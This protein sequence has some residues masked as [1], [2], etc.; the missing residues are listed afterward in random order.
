M[1]MDEILVLR[2][3][4]G[5]AG[6]ETFL[7]LH[8]SALL[9]SRRS[10]RRMD[11]P[12]R[13][14]M[15][16][17]RVLEAFGEPI[18]DGGQEAFV[19]GVLEK[20]DMSGL[21]VDCL[22]AYDCRSEKYRGLVERL[23]GQVFAL[24]LPFAPG[25]SRENIRKPFRE[26]LKDSHYDVVHIHS[27]SISVLAIMAAEAGKAGA[28]KVIVHSHAS[29]E[30]DNLKHKV[31]RFLASI[32]MSRY[33]TT[34]C[35]CSKEAAEWKYEPKYAA[36]AHII[37][38]GIDIE[39]FGYDPQK[40]TG[41]RRKLGI[42]DRFVIGHVGRFTKEKNHIFLIDIF[43]AVSQRDSAARLLLVGAGEEMGTIRQLVRQRCLEDRVIFTGSVTNVEDHLQAMDIFVLPSRFEGLGIAAVEAQCAGLPVIAS[44]RVP[45]SA[46]FTEKMVFLPLEAGPEKWAD[47]IILHRDSER[48][49]P[50]ISA[51]GSDIRL[52][53]KKVREL[54]IR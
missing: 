11:L 39:R 45:R 40:R 22:T 23:G 4:R 7:D 2:T 6:S 9:M 16:E 53:A 36:K 49:A 46:A 19:F 17:R 14:N 3:L 38:N 30:N 47:E 25:K 27:G 13:G 8:R 12:G 42:D 34:Y 43:E 31:L 48:A 28:G 41:I 5:A 51:A 54:Y 18:A 35:A 26:F 10:E 15:A 44:D 37:K 29:G 21:H 32:P 50:G 1:R 52:T 24:D 33:V 20:M